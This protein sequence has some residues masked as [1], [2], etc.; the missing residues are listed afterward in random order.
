MLEKKPHIPELYDLKH[1]HDSDDHMHYD[2]EN[3]MLEKLL[4]PYIRKN[5]NNA[6]FLDQLKDLWLHMYES[7]VYAKNFFNYT[8]SKDYTRHNH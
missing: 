7:A 5:T 8:V 3:H 2:Y 1:R 4:P 6:E